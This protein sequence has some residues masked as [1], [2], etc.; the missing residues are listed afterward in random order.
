MVTDYAICVL[1]VSQFCFFPVFVFFFKG[2]SNAYCYWDRIEI[3][4]FG[5]HVDAVKVHTHTYTYTLES[6]DW[7]EHLSFHMGKR[8][9]IGWFCLHF[10]FEETK[11]SI[12]CFIHK[13][14]VEKKSVGCS[15]RFNKI[16]ETFTFNASTHRT[17]SLFMPRN[18]IFVVVLKPNHNSRLVR[19]DYRAIG[20][21]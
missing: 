19:I 2:V 10:F 4:P 20:I 15:E 5:R 9:G 6:I 14:Y 17:I 13:H 3:I 8:D 16:I 1:F 7:C 11:T 18:D 21:T 12:F